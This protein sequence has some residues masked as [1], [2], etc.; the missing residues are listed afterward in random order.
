MRIITNVLLLTALIMPAHTVFAAGS[1]TQTADNATVVKTT[2][3]PNDMIPPGYRATVIPVSGD[4]LVYV[5]KGDRI[6]LLVTFETVTGKKE[7]VTATILQNV[8]VL[9]V[10]KPAKIVN[11]GAI[12]LLIIPNEAQYAALSAA[13]GKAG[14]IVRA[15]GDFDIEPMEIASFRKLFR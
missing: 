2:A 6:D 13:K 8:I 11:D 1:G 9:N 5:K 14:I 12:E 7:K 10:Q 4:Q 3:T 15:P